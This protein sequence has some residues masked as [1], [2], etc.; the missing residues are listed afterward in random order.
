MD[1]EDSVEGDPTEPRRRSFRLSGHR[2]S[3][4]LE[5]A[6]WAALKNIAARE[7]R[8]M[9]SIIEEVDDNRTGSLTAAVRVYV[10]QWL[11][12]RQQL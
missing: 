2:T 1:G 4:S 7:D 8:T 12:R 3:L 5:R 9:T 11:R 10:L 6:F